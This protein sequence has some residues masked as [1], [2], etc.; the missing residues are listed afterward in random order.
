VHLDDIAA[1]V[2]EHLPFGRGDLDL[3]ETLSALQGVGYSG[4]AAVE[5][6]RDSHRGPLAAAEAL[7]ALRAA[8]SASP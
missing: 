4:M 3:V 7:E 6:S 8:L 1:G 5:L 2:H